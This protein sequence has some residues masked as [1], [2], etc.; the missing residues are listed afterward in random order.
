[1]TDL[2]SKLAIGTVQFGLNYGINNWAGQVELQEVE[3]IL[4]LAEQLKVNTLD[5]ARAY[6]N[7]ELV[8]GQH[9]LLN[10]LIISKFSG[11]ESVGESLQ[12]SLKSIK[13]NNLYGYLAHSSD[14]LVKNPSY[15]DELL[16][17]KSQGLI[18][19]IGYSIYLPEQLEQL[20]EMG[21][22]P[23]L[24]QVQYNV[25]DRRFE[26]WF[27]ELKNMGIEIHTRSSFLQGLFF[28]QNPSPYFEAII[29]ILDKIKYLYPQAG[30]RAA[31]LLL[32]CLRN[33]YI[34]KVVIGIQD[35]EELR[36]NI[37]ALQ[38]IDSSILDEIEIPEFSKDLLLPYNWPTEK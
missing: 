37:N 11:G 19:Q 1:M 7:S 38:N 3:K 28:L 32:F 4:L 25:L 35:S 36:I 31:A 24:I 20:L 8:L 13:A 34:D 12:K 27:K 18:K 22:I 14:I 33:P 17:L 23:D 29:G 5:T 21:F 9:N 30:E 10:W 15:W 6:G 2:S 16:S 26:P